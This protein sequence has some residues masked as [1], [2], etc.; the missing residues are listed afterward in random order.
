MQL[1]AS[2]IAELDRPPAIV[3]SMKVFELEH[4]D[5]T[6]MR[7]TLSE[8]FD[9]EPAAGAGLA[10]GAGG[11]LG[12]AA[13]QLFQ[14]PMAVASGDNPPVS[15]R[16]AVDERTNSLIV[17]GPEN[18]LL[19]VQAVIKTLDLSDIHNR[20]SSVYRLKN[21]YAID[22]AATLTQFFTS[23]RNIEGT[24]AGLTT[25]SGTIVGPYTRLEQD[26]VVVALDNSMVAQLTTAASV[27]TLAT[28]NTQGTS[29]LLLISASPRNYPQVIKMIEELD[30]PQPQVI[31]QC[32]IAQLTLNNDFEFGIEF[33]LQNDVLFNRGTVPFTSASTVTN[34]TAGVTTATNANPGILPGNPGFNF[35]NL[36][37]LGNSTNASPGVV[38]GQGLSNFALGR[39]SLI[40]GL[41]NVGGL[42]LTASSQNVS[43][44]LRALQ[45]DGRLEVL[46]RPEIMTVDG[47]TARVV[48]GENFPYIGQVNIEGTSGALLPTVSFASI[49]V[50]LTVKPNI[51][52]DNRIYLEI[53]PEVSELREIV[54]VQTI[55]TTSGNIVQ[56]APRIQSTS[57][58]TVVSVN[59][60]QTVVLAGLIQK[61]QADFMRK[62][63]WLG[64]LPHVGCLFRFTQQRELRQE[65]LI[66][67]TP[68]II[69]NEA[70]AQ[71]IKDTEV[72]R[73]NWVLKHMDEMHGDIGLSQPAGDGSE[74]V[75]P[76]L[77]DPTDE[78]QM[79]RQ[80]SG[81]EPA[82][83]APS[84][85]AAPAQPADDSS[86]SNPKQRT[87]G[88][89]VRRVFR[90]R[91]DATKQ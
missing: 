5:A 82:S 91:K 47:R 2:I 20:K 76:S 83:G 11:A 54:N 65:L 50:I 57:A 55:S 40:D 64:D 81:E 16:V 36:N 87:L 9:L 17:S 72:A 46:S 90:D 56:Q 4:A 78:T 86:R 49:G 8:L 6:N 60:G 79:I 75:N 15:I 63:P 58:N 61:R 21:T 27:T 85:W 35:N 18:A 24:A 29:N 67:M 30:A 68:H 14:R 53:V 74:C 7:I 42:V 22:V 51:T 84:D 62:I 89:M 34:S 77:A 45:N 19:Q 10:G 70:D 31:I 25:A 69:R 12:T 59:D 52:P 38:G 71:R 1:M 33:G 73:V 37:P 41:T 28:P 44:M 13:G 88:G 26:V 3:A 48:V 66:I 43:A 39:S 23:K 80:M 32:V